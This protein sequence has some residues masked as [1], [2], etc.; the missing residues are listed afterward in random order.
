MELLLLLLL[1]ASD[2]SEVLLVA[3]IFILWRFDRQRETEAT[4]F[5]D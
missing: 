5:A 3:L 1:I 2:V 4:D